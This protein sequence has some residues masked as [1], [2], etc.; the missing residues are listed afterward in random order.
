MFSSSLTDSGNIKIHKNKL[1][2]NLE[3]TNNRVNSQII[4]VTA[5][6]KDSSKYSTSKHDN[7][8]VKPTFSIKE[9][10]YVLKNHLGEDSNTKIVY[11]DTKCVTFKVSSIDDMEKVN[12]CIEIYDRNI[13]SVNGK[14]SGMKSLNR[15]SQN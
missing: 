5:R 10:F 12:E 11:A 15:K 13:K 9:M 1:P 8:S 3:V 2:Q 7:L 4:W 6:Q 14:F